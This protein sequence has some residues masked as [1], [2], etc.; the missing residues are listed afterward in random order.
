MRIVSVPE[1]IAIE[2]KAHADGLTYK[3]MMDNAGGALADIVLRRYAHV[4]PKLVLGLIG[5]G[6][7]GGD[8]LIALREMQQ[9]GWQTTACLIKER[10]MD[11][12]LIQSLEK[13]GG[14]IN[15]YYIKNY[16]DD[17]KRL[18][19][20]TSI[21]LDGILGTGFK[22]PMRGTIPEVLKIVS[23]ELGNKPIVAVDCP[24]GTDCDSGASAPETLRAEVTVCM[25]ALK[26]GLVKMPA[27]GL[28]GEIIQ[29]GI[30]LGP[31][32][33]DRIQNSVIAADSK[34]VSDFLPSRCADGH[35]G[36]FGKCIVIGG[37][38]QYPGAPLLA[39]ESAYRIGS[40]LVCTGVPG[41]IYDGVI[42]TLR[43]SIWLV[44]PH[45]MGVLNEEAAKIVTHHAQKYDAM[46]VGPG[47][48]FDKSTISFMRTLLD[49][50]DKH[51]APASIGF[52]ATTK[53]KSKNTQNQPQFVFDAD[54]LRI[55]PTIENWD[56][57]LQKTAVLTPHPG[58]MAVLT[59]KTIKEIQNAR[60]ETARTF[61]TTHGH[62]L[63][64]KGATTIVASP[65]EVCSIVPFTTSALA[66]AG[67]GDVL[68]GMITGLLAQG[69]DAY[70]AA[71]CGAWLHGAAG[72]YA[73]RQH[74]QEAS[75]IAR[76]I[77]HQVPDILNK[78]TARP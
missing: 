3:Q 17:L 37:S 43:E 44:L 75:V 28:T 25:A 16:Q 7:N 12:P 46:L 55:L 34:F 4:V 62:V 14:I 45:E 54:A 26:Q 78:I 11:D 53:T 59:G 42:G 6:N 69:L 5:S 41:A 30:G 74:G 64:L 20:T 18:V 57:K 24:S 38:V 19:H 70:H 40:G 61:A 23:A 60:L 58:E 71:V 22:L 15:A 13:S 77:I 31:D 10:A 39:A 36:D 1:I 68:A 48:S 67:S 56:K 73:G 49:F 47:L 50:D 29:A 51:S 72:F 76:D 2:K 21:I 63:V 33:F 65:D 27:A 8:T 52:T 32:A 66:T 35:K 9:S